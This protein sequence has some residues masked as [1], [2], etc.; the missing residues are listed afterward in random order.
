MMARRLLAGVYPPFAALAIVAVALLL[1]P[2]ADSASAGD[3][4]AATATGLVTI[5]F[6]AEVTLVVDSVNLLGGAISVGDTITGSYAFDATTPDSN[7]ISTV[8]DYRQVSS[9]HGIIVN[10]DGF[11]FE[12]D[13][14][15]VDFL[16]EVTNDHGAPPQD[17]YLLISY[18]NLPL[19]NGLEVAFIS[20]QL[21]DHTASAHTSAGLPKVPPNLSD[22]ASGLGLDLIGG[23]IP[24]GSGFTY[25]VRAHVTSVQLTSQPGPTI[26]PTFTPTVTPTPTPLFP[27]GG[28]ALDGELRTLPL[29]TSGTSPGAGSTVQWLA[30]TLLALLVLGGG[31]ALR[32]RRR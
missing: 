23:V 7:P 29:E 16:V 12:T 18:N 13:P 31:V 3:G 5:D 8:G 26:T 24:F 15:N 11:V 19:S 25:L 20:W 2:R 30:A 17:N 22:W 32:R 10:A 14:S 28:V 9:P 4:S 27:V 6:T 21:T 1:L